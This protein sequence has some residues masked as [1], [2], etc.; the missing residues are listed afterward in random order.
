MFC[1]LCLYAICLLTINNR[2]HYI[3]NVDNTLVLRRVSEIHVVQQ[4]CLLNDFFDKLK[5][6]KRAWLTPM[7]LKQWNS[8]FDVCD[9]ILVF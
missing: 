4:V 9:R 1:L 2:T 7:I 5:A 8:A 3:L 6:E